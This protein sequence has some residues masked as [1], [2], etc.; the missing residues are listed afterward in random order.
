MIVFHAESQHPT[1]RGRIESKQ[2]ALSENKRKAKVFRT[3]VVQH[4]VPINMRQ[5]NSVNNF[6][7]VFGGQQHPVPELITYSGFLR[8]KH[9]KH[10]YEIGLP[11]RQRE[12]IRTCIVSDDGRGRHLV[13]ATTHVQKLCGGFLR[14]QYP[15]RWR[16]RSMNTSQSANSIMLR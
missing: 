6:C 7:Q 15:P 14:H 4:R 3:V 2:L 1:A 16:I 8:A 10:R 13:I 9:I 5:L 11:I 12:H